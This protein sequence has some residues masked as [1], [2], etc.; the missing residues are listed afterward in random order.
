M[1]LFIKDATQALKLWIHDQKQYPTI[2]MTS[3]ILNIIR[4]STEA[5]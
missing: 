1:P 5:K 2:L 3:Q 4:D